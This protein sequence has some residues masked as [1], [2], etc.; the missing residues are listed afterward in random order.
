MYRFLE[1]FTT[2]IYSP[3]DKRISLS[4]CITLWIN[5][6][7]MNGHGWYRIPFLVMSMLF[8]QGLLQAQAPSR[9]S[10]ETMLPPEGEHR[11]G[12]EISA[13]LLG[14]QSQYRGSGAGQLE[15]ALRGAGR[16]R[17]RQGPFSIGL[18]VSFHPA[19][20]Q[21]DQVPMYIG[22]VRD[23]NLFSA[24]NA[25]PVLNVAGTPLRDNELF[26]SAVA[27]PEV[28]LAGQLSLS[29]GAEDVLVLDYYEVRD[30][31][32]NMWGL[33]VPVRWHF[34]PDKA[35][36]P[37]FFAEAGLG[38]DV[39]RM[40]ATYDLVRSSITMDIQPLVITLTRSISMQSD[41]VPRD[42]ELDQSVVFT[43]AM[44]G[45]GVDLGRFRVFLRLQRTVSAA[46]EQDGDTFRRV[47]GNVFALPVIA[48]AWNDPE[49]ATTLAGG[50]IVPYGRTDIPKDADG[51][52]QSYDTA[53]GVDR[54]WDRSQAVLGISF[55]LR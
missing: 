8:V 50:G 45:G 27:L 14:M 24:G 51:P 43:R 42:G 33:M 49:V 39:L 53:T 1:A 17:D 38:V 19:M 44:V 46:L 54:F 16:I 37:R 48:E 32:M 55:R 29:P 15:F 12:V 35:Q 26:L 13:G 30:V 28:Q 3:R 9:N 47:R 4:V 22:H 18:M 6:L 41:V 7:H 52:A 2:P 34:G 23:F 21:W 25:Q 40:Q 20:G 5:T 11:G 36:G 10:E 31:H